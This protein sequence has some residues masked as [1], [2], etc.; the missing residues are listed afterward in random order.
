MLWKPLPGATASAAEFTQARSL[1]M[2]ILAL[3][4]WN[5]LVM[6]DRAGEYEAALA[7]FGQFQ[8]SGLPVSIAARGRSQLAAR[9]KR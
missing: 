3:E 8:Y 4:I 9:L 1:V 6:E 2:E 7:V 5:P